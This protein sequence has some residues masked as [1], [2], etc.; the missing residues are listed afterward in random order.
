MTKTFGPAYDEKKDGARIGAQMRAVRDA[1]L[2]KDI[3][4]S[5]WWTLGELR[6]AT[7]Y[8]EA[9]IS[10]QLRHLRKKRFGAFEVEK[11]R[12]ITR[13]AAVSGARANGGGLWEYRIRRPEKQLQLGLTA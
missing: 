12:R 7:G 9:S 6:E 8:P 5:A 13:E 10:A 3:D 1:M 2:W 11:R 4:V